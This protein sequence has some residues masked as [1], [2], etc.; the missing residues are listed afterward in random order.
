MSVLA[1]NGFSAP[2]AYRPVADDAK[3]TLRRLKA[4]SGS[5]PICWCRR[6]P[7]TSQSFNLSTARALGL[8]V[9]AILLARADKVIE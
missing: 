5:L 6:R 7:G 2:L 8:N 4:C 1:Q 9:S 3:P